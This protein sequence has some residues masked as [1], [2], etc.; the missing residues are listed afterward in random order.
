[1]YFENIWDRY[2]IPRV[3]LEKICKYQ[4]I[5]LETGFIHVHKAVNFCPEYDLWSCRVK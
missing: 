5:F 2:M 4:D 3:I 1:M